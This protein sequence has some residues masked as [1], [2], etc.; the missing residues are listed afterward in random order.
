MKYFCSSALASALRASEEASA[1]GAALSTIGGCAISG[2]VGC[3]L[4]VALVAIGL[5]PAVVAVVGYT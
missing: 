5:V 4:L 3:L 1:V 2:I